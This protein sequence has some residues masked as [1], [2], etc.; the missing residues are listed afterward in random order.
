MYLL[1]LPRGILISRSIFKVIYSIGWSTHP[2]PLYIYIGLNFGE[3]LI[4]LSCKYFLQKF[5]RNFLFHNSLSEFPLSEKPIM[6]WFNIII[7]SHQ[8]LD[9]H[10]SLS[11]NPQHLGQADLQNSAQYILVTY[12]NP[13]NILILIP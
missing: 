13:V 6:G 3:D 11:S 5:V 12:C 9:V 2:F 4:Q 7:R 8:N 10:N 1:L